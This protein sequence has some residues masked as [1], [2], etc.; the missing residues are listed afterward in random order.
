MP[1]TN[2]NARGGIEQKKKNTTTH[3]RSVQNRRERAGSSEILQY[4]NIVGR[5]TTIILLTL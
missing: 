1:I 2:N 5:T 4:F 3:L